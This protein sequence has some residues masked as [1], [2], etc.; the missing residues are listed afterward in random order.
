MYLFYK[1]TDLILFLVI[2]LYRDNK[3]VL[4]LVCLLIY[5]WQNALHTEEFFVF[6]LP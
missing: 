3:D 2:V 4:V 5:M 6:I 1:F